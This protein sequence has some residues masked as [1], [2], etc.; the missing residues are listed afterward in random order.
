MNF[1][2]LINKKIESKTVFVLGYGAIG[3]AFTDVL[4]QK[5]PS[6]NIIVCDVFELPKS[7]TRFK[8]IHMKISRDNI[9]KIFDYVGNGD[10][11]VDLSTNICCLELW[12][13]CMKNGVMY[14]N[15]A[16]EEWEDSENVKSF[17]K[18]I[19]ELYKTS[20]GCRHDEVMKME[21]WNPNLGPTSVFEHGMNPGL[22]SHFVK[23]GILD[24]AEHFLANKS[25]QSFSDLNFSLIKKYLAEKNY[26]KLAQ[27]L[28]L[29]T[30]H[31]SEVDNQW[32]TNPPT[33]RKEKFYNTWSCRGFLTEGLV[34]IQVVKGSH[35]DEE[36]HQFPSIRDNTCFTSW[37]PSKN[38][39]AKSWNPSADM[40]G[41][42][43]PHGEAFTINAFLTDPETGYSPSQYY[44]YD[45][46]PY[47]KDFVENLSPDVKVQD[48]NPEMEVLHPMNHD[49]HGYDRVG[50]MLIYKKNRGW[51]SGSIMDEFDS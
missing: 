1:I 48:F 15:T 51:W 22:I 2:N 23:K 19:E 50:A 36:N 26:T 14:M 10:I 45:L 31:C 33:D 18:S 39:K 5:H 28:G 20:L 24:T 38:Y 40:V 9:T 35:E 27:E 29:H 13:L 11:L 21:I 17:P 25:D 7:E 4:C 44:V 8:Y 47:A 34:P 3:K 37:T 43:I 30:I 32:V 42:L 12:P 41:T 49:L 16:M 6:T 46:N